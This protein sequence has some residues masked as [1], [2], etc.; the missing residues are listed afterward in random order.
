MQYKKLGEICEIL[1]GF[2]FKSEQYKSE[3]VK[4]IRITNVQKGFI[5][6]NDPLYYSLEDFEGLERYS[7]K[8]NDL[9]MSLTGNVG[10]VG[11][12]PPSMLPAGLNQRV[13]C[14]RPNEQ[15][16]CK[17]FLFHIL[18]SYRF[19]NDAI[20]N[21]KGIAQK[22]L[23]TEW[24][25]LYPVPVPSLA[26][27]SRIVSELDLLTSL[28]DNQKKQLDELSKL[29]QST[30]FSMFG[31]PVENEKEWPVKKL[32]EVCEFKNGIN[33]N[34]VDNGGNEYTFLG[35]SDFK[36]NVCIY[37]EQL[38]VINIE[39]KI[40]DDYFLENNDIV[41]VRS[42]G[43][44]DLVGR[45]VL[46]KVGNEKVTYS[47][48]CIRCRIV[49]DINSLFLIWLLKYPTIKDCLTNAGRGCNI[50]NVNQKVLNNLLIPFP[51]LPLQTAFA[52]KI[53]AIEEMKMRVKSSIAETQKLFDARMQEIFG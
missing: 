47:G 12:I 8:E 36:D 17:K 4:I 21:A 23:S 39:E 5:S 40:S 10:R 28:I 13:A 27:Q 11:L 16:L 1:N 37:S 48:F 41:F 53:S 29:Q 19:E 51:P 3:G 45:A 44:K 24:L 46:I 31:D 32:G 9:L 34:K 25:K 43:S 6:D 33:F 50:S 7:L 49:S 52:E 15:V 38:G 14:L 42:N 35:V 20:Y 22:N 26:S 30:F 2:A 18:N